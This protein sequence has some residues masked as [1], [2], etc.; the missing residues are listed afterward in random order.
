M[1]FDPIKVANQAASFAMKKHGK[2]AAPESEEEQKE[3]PK[4]EKK[5]AAKGKGFPSKF[6]K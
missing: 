1:A 6:G 3:T 5:D 2:K 4:K